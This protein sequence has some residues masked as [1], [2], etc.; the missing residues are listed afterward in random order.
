[1]R[2]QLTD[3]EIA[4]LEDAA[5]H[6][7]LLK[8]DG[9]SPDAAVFELLLAMQLIVRRDGILEITLLGQHLLKLART[10]PLGD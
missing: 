6:P 8:V 3:V 2:I 4:F 9:D 1:M 7:S 10:Q 5:H